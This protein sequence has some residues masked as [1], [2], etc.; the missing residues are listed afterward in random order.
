MT[1]S[2]LKLKTKC[3]SVSTLYDT[4][5]NLPEDQEAEA[6]VLRVSYRGLIYYSERRLGL[7]TKNYTALSNRSTGFHEVL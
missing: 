7:L 1:V 5:K 4:M 6:E 2:K 3:I